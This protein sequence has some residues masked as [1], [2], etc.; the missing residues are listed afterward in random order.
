MMTG[1]AV[2]A[3]LSLRM[4]FNTKAHVDFFNRHHPIH[5]LNVT[6]ALLALN[7][8]VD[9]RAVPEFYEIRQRID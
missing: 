1:H 2:E 4:T 5:V 6:V 9:M 3:R 7:A 8:G